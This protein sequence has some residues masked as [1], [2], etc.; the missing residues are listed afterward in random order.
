MT[1]TTDTTD[2]LT[3]LAEPQSIA[4]GGY[5]VVLA[6]GL[7]SEELVDRIAAAAGPAV[8]A[9]PLGPYTGED[10]TE[11]YELEFASDSEDIA[12][13]H[14]R[15]GDLAFAVAYGYWQGELAVGP[16]V[17]R[18]GAEVFHLEFEEANGKPVP[19]FF[20]AWR[21][22]RPLCSFNLHLDGSWGSAEVEGEPATAAAVT[23]ALAEAGLPDLGRGRDDLHRTS[24]GVLA[25]SFGLAL[26]RAAVVEGELPA[27]L[28]EVG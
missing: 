12:L 17:S 9:R 14:G 11:E 7:A 25:R 26:P 6:R 28:L 24:L 13:R 15:I 5:S 3:W 27:V 18:D 2:G 23:A 19:P 20:S 10:L 8:V 1:T 21:D 16:A 4:Y 22:G